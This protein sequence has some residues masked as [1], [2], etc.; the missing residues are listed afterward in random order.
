MMQIGVRIGSM[1]AMFTNEF[2]AIFVIMGIYILVQIAMSIVISALNGS[3]V[4]VYG[5]RYWK[6]LADKGSS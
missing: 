2:L 4:L 6:E 1:A 3:T 5:Y